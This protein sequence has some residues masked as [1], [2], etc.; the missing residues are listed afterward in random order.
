MLHALGITH[1]VSVGEC[2]LVPPPGHGTY[3][4]AAYGGAGHSSS[5]HRANTLIV[6]RT[7]S[8]D[9]ASPSCPDCRS[10]N[11]HRRRRLQRYGRHCL[12]A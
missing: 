7:S 10:L 6:Y 8:T 11:N 3:G 5:N 4:G 9:R 12:H 1:V 2:A